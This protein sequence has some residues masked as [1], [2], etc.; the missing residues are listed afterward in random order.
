[1]R[2]PAK[3]VLIGSGNPEEG[4]LRPQLLDRFGLSVEVTTPDDIDSRIAVVKRRDEFESDPAAFVARWRKEEAAI[5]RKI[6]AA[7]KRLP[8]VTTSDEVLKRASELCMRLGTDGLR[9]ELTMMRAARALA[10]FE[11][12]TTVDEGHLAAVAPSALRHRLRRDPLD[13]VGSTARVARAV[14]EM[15]S[16]IAD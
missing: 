1:V 16:G 3:F 14:E 15:L 11:G 12:D 4:E 5:Q 6:V 13:E 8:T 7:R 9:G 10:S 2:H